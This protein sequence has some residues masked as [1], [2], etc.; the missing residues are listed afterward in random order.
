MKGKIFSNPLIKEEDRRASYYRTILTRNL[1]IFFK[2]AVR[3]AL[4]NPPRAYFFFK[5]LRWQKKA[6]LTRTRWQEQGINIP[7]ILIFSLTTRC[8]LTCKGCYAQA[9]HPPSDKEMGEA[10]IRGMME[11]AKKLGISFFIIAGGEPFMRPE[12]LDITKDFPEILFL[13]FTNGLLI[14][15]KILLRLKKQKNIIPMVSL[16]GH[17]ED[18]DGRRGHGVHDILQNLIGKFKSKG[19]FFGLSLTITRTTFQVLTDYHFVKNLVKRGCKF[20]LFLEYTAIIEGTENLILTDD[21][22][23]LLRDLM[24]SF[25]SKFSALF[26]TV[27]GHEVEVGGCLAAGR[28][29]VHIT[30]EGDLE[31]CPFAPF[32]DTNLRDLSLKDALQSQFMKGIRQHPEKLSPTQGGCALW[33]RR[34]WVQSLLNK[35][36]D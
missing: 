5:T 10:K 36:N 14:D 16:E 31:P 23:R 33:K 18:T 32:S 11:E 17:T 12:I 2:D 27:P 26:I 25:H 24:D 21:Q 13:L 6:A 20:F 30:A 28:G 1:R 22:R 35:T 34:K 4:T 19:I 9:L 15:D 29:F 3:V 7:P 8:N